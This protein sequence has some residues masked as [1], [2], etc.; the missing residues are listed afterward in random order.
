M[1]FTSSMCTRKYGFF[2]GKISIIRCQQANYKQKKKIFFG[3]R[4]QLPLLY[5]PWQERERESPKIT[6]SREKSGRVSCP[7]QTSQVRNLPHTWPRSIVYWCRGVAPWRTQDRFIGSYASEQG[8]LLTCCPI[9]KLLQKKGESLPS[10]KDKNGFSTCE[11]VDRG[12]LF[13]I[14]TYI[15][16]KCS[17]FSH[18]RRKW[19]YFYRNSTYLTDLKG[20]GAL[21]GNIIPKSHKKFVTYSP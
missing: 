8:E 11:K 1:T 7:L 10:E 14:G 13:V 16:V 6:C 3:F 20:R 18:D 2:K 9:R 19:V 17:L 5:Y 12:F 15:S 4:F 21:T